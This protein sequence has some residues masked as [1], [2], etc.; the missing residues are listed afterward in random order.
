MH[1]HLEI[2]LFKIDTIKNVLDH[3]PEECPTL[4]SSKANIHIFQ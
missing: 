4:D 1:L 3:N 2:A